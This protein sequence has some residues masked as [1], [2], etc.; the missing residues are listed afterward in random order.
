MLRV[1]VQGTNKREIN[2]CGGLAT[3]YDATA[4]R[5]VVKL[6]VSGRTFQL[7][8]GNLREE[9]TADAAAGSPGRAGDGGG[10]LLGAAKASS[11]LAG[12]SAAN[13]SS[14]SSSSFAGAGAGDSALAAAAL[15]AP[16]PE[17][18]EDSPAGRLA[19]RT[20]EQ[21]HW[22][23]VDA[24]ATAEQLPAAGE[25]KR[26]ER[27]KGGEGEMCAGAYALIHT[28]MRRKSSERERERERAL[29]CKSPTVSSNAAL[30]SRFT[31]VLQGRGNR[32]V[33]SR[34]PRHR[35]SPARCRPA[36][37]SGSKK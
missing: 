15:L 37:A 3:R 5:Y 28:H 8:A 27:G 6:D 11:A 1:Q 25:T 7:K 24:K 10:G 16:L 2:G 35:T 18:F 12:A 9:T 29:C 36:R 14:S 4:A 23:A 30:S 22:R 20:A 32:S 19:F 13:Y 17:A 26:L 31:V 34:P 33:G 21:M